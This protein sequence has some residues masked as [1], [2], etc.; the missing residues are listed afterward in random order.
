MA[1]QHAS[2]SHEKTFLFFHPQL[3]F[4]GDPDDCP[5]PHPDYVCATDV[6]GQNI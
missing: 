6:L 2:Y 5:L 1:I 4:A 3:E